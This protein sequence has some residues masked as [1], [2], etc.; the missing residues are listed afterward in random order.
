MIVAGLTAQRLDMLMSLL[1][2]ARYIHRMIHF[3]LLSPYSRT[4]MFIAVG[5]QAL[6]PWH[7]SG[8]P[9][10]TRHIISILARTT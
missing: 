1:K 5:P 8:W 4:G 6:P 2:Y 9:R 3:G 10:I 7:S